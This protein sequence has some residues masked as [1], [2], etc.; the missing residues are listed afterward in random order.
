MLP[1]PDSGDVELSNKTEEGRVPVLPLRLDDSRATVT[2]CGYVTPVIVMLTVIN[3]VIVCVV[4]LRR[5]MRN[6]TNT[7]LVGMAV[8]DTLTG[9]MPLPHYM[10]FYTAGR[11]RDYV[12]Y[13]W[14]V[15][16]AALTDHLP[17]AFHTASIWLTVTLAF[18]RYNIV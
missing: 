6:A 2:V 16:Y 4:L 8:A 9:L 14:C 13:N 10:H 11:Y 15:M 18:H 5:A 12:P 3:N 17:T 1:V 7:L